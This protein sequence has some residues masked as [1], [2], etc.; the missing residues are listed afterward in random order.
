MFVQLLNQNA[1]NILEKKRA[2]YDFLSFSYTWVFI[3]SFPLWAVV[4]LPGQRESSGSWKVEMEGEEESYKKGPH[5]DECSKKNRK[6]KTT[7]KHHH[8]PKY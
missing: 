8:S 6:N 5:T 1:T 4:V 7:F 2:I 3:K